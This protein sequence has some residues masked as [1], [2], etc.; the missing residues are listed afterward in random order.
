MTVYYA[1]LKVV[2]DEVI[3]CLGECKHL[4][5]CF[6]FLEE[7]IIWHQLLRNFMLTKIRKSNDAGKWQTANMTR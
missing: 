7:N 1:P 3:G 2:L 5:N 6:A 4:L